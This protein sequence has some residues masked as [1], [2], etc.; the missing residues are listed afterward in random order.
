MPEELIVWFFVG[1]A[2]CMAFVAFSYRS[3]NPLSLST[4]EM[5][6][7][8]LA[9]AQEQTNKLM[10]ELIAVLSYES[11]KRFLGDK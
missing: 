6:L 1:F 5:D 10:V 9:N 3:N 8:R 2:V 7:K 11:R 4:L